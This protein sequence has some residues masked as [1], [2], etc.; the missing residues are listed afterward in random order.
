MAEDGIPEILAEQ[1]LGHQVPGMRGLYAHAS[2]RMRDDLKHALQTRWE[3]SLRA[4]AA[5][6]PHSPLPLLDDLLAAEVTNRNQ[7]T[8]GDREK[9]ISQIPPNRP[10]RPARATLA[11]RGEPELTGSDL[12]RY[13][14]S[15]GG[16]KGTRT[17]DPLLANNRHHVHQRP[18]PQVTVPERVSASL[19]IRTC[20]G[21][22]VLYSPCR[23][24]WPPEG[25]R[26]ADHTEPPGSA[27]ESSLDQGAVIVDQAGQEAQMH[28]HAIA[29]RHEVDD[30]AH[31]GGFL[32]TGDN[33]SP[34]WIWAGSRAS[35]R[36]V[37]T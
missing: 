13:L 1:R 9:M 8:P 31:R 29:R 18:S 14:K 10:R 17:P 30:L 16:A 12:A 32:V 25:H 11:I 35:S 7:A 5:I 19:Q 20:C 22:F 33:K 36:K 4:R 23:S 6:S 21:T 15:E 24:G 28:D 2:D 3:D 26:S 27:G 34:G 37:Q